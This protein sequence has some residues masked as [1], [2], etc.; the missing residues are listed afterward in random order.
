[1]PRLAP[2]AVE[3]ERTSAEQMRLMLALC[4]HMS[5][6]TTCLAVKRVGRRTIT[7]VKRMV[8]VFL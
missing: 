3:Q 2:A 7:W 8:G 1:M 4:P 6:N 5:N